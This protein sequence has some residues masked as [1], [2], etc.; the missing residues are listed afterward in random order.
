MSWSKPELWLRSSS[1]ACRSSKGRRG[2]CVGSLFALSLV[3]VVAVA[4]A[5][6]AKVQ[7]R[8]AAQAA[9]E[10]RVQRSLAES[11]AADA[12]AQS[13]RAEKQARLSKSREL[14][15]AAIK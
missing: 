5:I 14:A 4:F 13:R 2:G 6:W 3:F 1:G 12:L 7:G 8:L 9:D 11:A 10:A 15:M